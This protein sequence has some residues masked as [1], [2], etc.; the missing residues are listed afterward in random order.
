LLDRA[1]RAEEE[2]QELREKI[3]DLKEDNDVLRQELNKLKA[4]ALKTTGRDRARSRDEKDNDTE[5][6]GLNS[7]NLQKQLD[8]KLLT[9]KTQNQ[10]IQNLNSRIAHLSQELTTRNIMLSSQK[11]EIETMASTLSTQESSQQALMHHSKS[12]ESQLSSLQQRLEAAEKGWAESESKLRAT[13][14]NMEGVQSQHERQRERERDLREQIDK[15]TDDLERVTRDKEELRRREM[16][17]K[18]DAERFREELD[19]EKKY[20]DRREGDLKEEIQRLAEELRK[21]EAEKKEAVDGFALEVRKLMGLNGQQVEMLKQENKDLDDKIMNEIRKR[22]EDE[23]RFRI[24]ERALYEEIDR[25]NE[26]NKRTGSRGK[27]QKTGSTSDHSEH[28]RQIAAKAHEI[29][30]LTAINNQ[31][32]ARANILETELAKVQ[33]RAAL[34]EEETKFAN[35][36]N[37]QL[38]DKIKF[39]QTAESMHQKTDFEIVKELNDLRETILQLKEERDKI[40]KHLSE[41]GVETKRQISEITSETFLGYIQRL[42]LEKKSLGEELVDREGVIGSLRQQINLLE[43]KEKLLLEER[44]SLQTSMDRAT[45]EMDRLRRRADEKEREASGHLD[46]LSRRE[47]EMAADLQEKDLLLRAC[48]AERDR[49]AETVAELHK[50]AV[51]SEQD[52]AETIQLLAETARLQKDRFL[53][54]IAELRSDSSAKRPDEALSDSIQR[55]ID[56]CCSVA[57]K[58]AKLAQSD[59]CLRKAQTK[60]GQL[61]REIKTI[62]QIQEESLLQQVLA[63]LQNSKAVLTKKSTLTA[64]ESSAAADMTNKIMQAMFSEERV[65]PKTDT[66]ADALFAE[67]SG[68]QAALRKSQAECGVLNERLL[69]LEI[70]L[71]RAKDEG[72]LADRENKRL[73]KEAKK[74]AKL[75]NEEVGTL[76]DKIQS[77]PQGHDVQ[78]LLDTLQA[79]KEEVQSLKEEVTRKKE[80]LDETRRIRSELELRIQRLEN[81]NTEVTRENSRL[82]A[83][84]EANIKSSDQLKVYRDNVQQLK[85]EK[86]ALKAEL[87]TTKTSMTDLKSELSRKETM[88]SKLKESNKQAK[89]KD[90]T[91]EKTE[92]QLVEAKS[93]LK[94][95]RVD[96]ERKDAVITS[97]SQKAK[98]FDQRLEDERTRM[99]S[100]LKTTKKNVVV[101]NKELEELRGKNKEQAVLEQQ[102]EVLV[103]VL[104]RLFKE[105]LKEI[106]DAGRAEE[107]KEDLS[108]F[109]ESMQILDLDPQQL[110]AF[111]STH[112]QKK[113]DEARAQM[114]EE[115]EKFDNSLK[116]GDNID[117]TK[118]YKMLSELIEDRVH[119]PKKVPFN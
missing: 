75:F 32:S 19:R 2:N 38:L 72:R 14:D 53:Q 12:L 24:K 93:T 5:E 115:L 83:K 20:K 106:Y 23:E 31:L 119:I 108:K 41:N 6:M 74:T 88:L 25:L 18:N 40:M 62:K 36:K 45:E 77:K 82:K 7:K 107:S 49:L 22:H 97:L 51:K 67:L 1:N 43:A 105:N 39:Y 104:R 15:L 101:K 55:L 76:L 94:K 118:V 112:A 35:D 114:D 98:E 80:A 11:S 30:D 56:R 92:K 111:V 70:E 116:I 28:E 57:Q 69:V 37:H 26:G 46:I 84:L 3:Y 89:D 79:K 52:N 48:L 78:S 91:L 113:V 99:E 59:D 90:D 10:E 29:L 42:T 34:L 64:K 100:E 27:R 47:H 110:K 73:V 86:E 61:K 4:E 102:L 66:D 109:K 87:E 68:V 33:R 71:Q 17:A 44:Q 96:L 50:V 85:L 103:L 21:A 63:A 117:G 54:A 95:L 60:I 58:D 8:L 16:N 13:R 9:I 65:S 81:D